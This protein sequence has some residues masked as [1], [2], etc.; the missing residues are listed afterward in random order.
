METEND[1]EGPF[2]TLHD[3][4]ARREDYVS[5]TESTKYPLFLCATR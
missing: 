2:Q 4:P 3:T 1:M 5:I